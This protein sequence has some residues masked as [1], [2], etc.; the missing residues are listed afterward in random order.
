MILEKNTIIINKSKVN[1]ENSLKVYNIFSQD[2][3]YLIEKQE[4]KI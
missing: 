1:T 3:S 2:K 4:S